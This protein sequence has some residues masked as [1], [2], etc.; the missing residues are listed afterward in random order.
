MGIYSTNRFNSL[1][2]DITLEAAEGY[3]G[4]IG[5]A[6]AMLEGYQ[7]DM[8]IFNGVIASDFQAAAAVHEGAG[9][10]E[11]YV[12]QEASLK[13]AWEKLKEF[14]KKL[15]EK[16]K[17]LFKAFIAKMDSVFMKDSA[18]FYKKYEKDIRLKDK[19]TDFSVKV[20]APKTEGKYVLTFKEADTFAIGSY[21]SADEVQKLIDDFDTE[22]EFGKTAGAYIEK[23]DNSVTPGE[24]EKTYTDLLLDDM[25][26]VEFNSNSILGG[27]VGG[28]LNQKKGLKEIQDAND[29]IEKQ[30]KNIIAKIDKLEKNAAKTDAGSAGKNVDLRQA[31]VISG[32]SKGTDND[33]EYSK[34]AGAIGDGADDAVIKGVARI[35]KTYAY[36]RKQ[37]NV[38][39]EVFNKYASVSIK[40]YKDICASARKVFAAAVAWSPKAEATL[41][42]AAGEAAYYEA[43]DM[44]DTMYDIA[45]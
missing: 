24:F 39:Q 12:L 14:F 13:G 1:G 26:D 20:R 29:K 30:I 2:A 15:G 31:T 3:N 4:E 35:Q 16:I 28:I 40:T 27:W 37:A 33:I 43:V 5:A 21:N 44:I 10:D 18:A 7:N 34:K 17:G 42:A 22:E 25:D 41:V 19:W 38:L 9:D 23:F 6:L 45:D 8:A 11:V 32:N 36:A